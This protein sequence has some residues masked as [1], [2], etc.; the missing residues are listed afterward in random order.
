[1]T[2]IA[3]LTERLQEVEIHSSPHLP[4]E[5]TAERAQLQEE[6]ESTERCLAICT[7]ALD[8]ISEL[9]T[10]LVKEFSRYLTKRL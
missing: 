1:M 7:K 8:Y 6:K 5:V 3:N 2:K 4:H 9:Q 10:N